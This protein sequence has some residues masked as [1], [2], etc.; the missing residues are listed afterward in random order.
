MVDISDVEIVVRGDVP[1]SATEYARKKIIVLTERL[2][3]PMLHARVR[4]THE[5]DPAVARP[6]RA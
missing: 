5:P 2:T 3:T 1:E 4:L 6:V